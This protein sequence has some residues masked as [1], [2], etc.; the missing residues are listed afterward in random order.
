MLLSRRPYRDLTTEFFFAFRWNGYRMM[1][2]HRMPANQMILQ[3]SGVIITASLRY[4]LAV[5]LHRSG[6]D[7]ILAKSRAQRHSRRSN[8]N[9]LVRFF[10]LPAAGFLRGKGGCNRPTVA[11]RSL[12]SASLGTP[13]PLEDMTRGL[14]I[15][16]PY[17]SN[18]CGDVSSR[19]A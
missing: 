18:M 2:Q 9:G 5:T 4:P 10:I 14:K 11:Q 12:T 8:K 15:V 19:C 7:S 3:T 13:R 16:A 1:T 6:T 17:A